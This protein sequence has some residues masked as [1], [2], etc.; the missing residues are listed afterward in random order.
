MREIVPDRECCG[1]YQIREKEL[2]EHEDDSEWDESILVT[3]D[4]AIEPRI[5]HHISIIWDIPEK[6][7]NRLYLKNICLLDHIDHHTSQS[8]QEI[9]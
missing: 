4:I 9:T 5:P 1:V 7:K 3:H 6:Y 8:K 2:V